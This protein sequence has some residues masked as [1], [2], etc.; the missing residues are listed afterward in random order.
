[1]REE[2]GTSRCQDL[3]DAL[4]SGVR[5]EPPLP[6][7]PSGWRQ[8][9]LDHVYGEVVRR[10]RRRVWSHR[11][12]QPWLTTQWILMRSSGAQV[13]LDDVRYEGLP[14]AHDY[15]PA[16]QDVRHGRFTPPYLFVAG[17]SRT[18][19]TSVQNVVKDAFPRHL[20]PGGWNAPGHPLRLWWYPK[21][22]VSVAER[23]ADLGPDLVRVILTVRPAVSSLA[24]HAVYRGFR[25][26]EDL[27]DAWV[28]TEA[29]DWLAMTEVGRRPEVLVVD[30]GLLTQ[31]TPAMLSG[32][33]AE[34]L[35]LTPTVDD[36]AGQDWEQVSSAGI[37]PDV[38]DDVQVSNL[39]HADRARLLETMSEHIRRTLGPRATELDEAFAAV[40]RRSPVA[41]DVEGEQVG[42]RDAG[43]R[44]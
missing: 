3:A 27:P 35:G 41:P 30:F 43:T 23:L 20:Q 4:W 2:L 13:A 31:W 22:N 19:T 44:R 10:R 32:W 25:G 16:Y 38:I 29:D 42:E 36:L 8:W 12:A 17:Y 1:M 26:P 34:R 24:S 9:Y 15:E 39:P 40:V 6:T 7:A 21:H 14:G 28:Q 37:S 33:L 18:G 11:S 5:H